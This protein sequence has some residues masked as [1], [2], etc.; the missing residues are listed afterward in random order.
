MDQ[1]QNQEALRYAPSPRPDDGDPVNL[2]NWALQELEA[3]SNVLNGIGA[4][5]VEFLNAPPIKPRNGDVR[6]AD[7]VNWNPGGQGRGYYGYD[8]QTSSWRKLG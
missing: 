1:N 6:M 3:I 2:A 5:H 8:E 4:G 7:G